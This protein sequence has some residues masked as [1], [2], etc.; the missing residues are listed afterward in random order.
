MNNEIKEILQLIGNRCYCGEISDDKCEKYC[1][2][3]TNLQE[4]NKKLKEVIVNLI[5]DDSN[6]QLRIEK[7]IEYIDKRIFVDVEEQCSILHIFGEDLEELLKI[8][9][10]E[11]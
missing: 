9:K 10:G 11:E 7:A 6:L 2:Y 5:K 3:I 8:L 1:N 4:E